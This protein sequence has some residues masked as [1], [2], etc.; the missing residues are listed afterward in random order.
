M[1]DDFVRCYIPDM[2]LATLRAVQ[3]E[4]G[5]LVGWRLVQGREFDL[6]RSYGYEH[7]IEEK[8]LLAAVAKRCIIAENRNPAGTKPSLIWNNALDI[9][10]VLTL[11]SIARGRFV[12]AS[13]VEKKIGTKYTL[14]RAL[15]VPEIAGRW[16][17]VPIERFGSFIREAMGH[18][19]RYPDWLKDSGFTP[20]IYTYT[21]AQIAYLTAPSI[22]EMGLYWVTIESIAG[23]YIESKAITENNKKERVKRFITDMGYAGSTWTFLEEVID[24]WYKT[25]NALFHEGKQELP[26]G[27]LGIRRQQ[28][29]DFTSLVLVEMLQKQGEAVRKEVATRIQDYK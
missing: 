7:G 26:I 6:E 8:D 19:E 17:I 24:D 11:L 15:I 1:S 28:A 13:F 18:I 16:D 4:S 14:S 27:L 22:L 23:T 3:E 29:R 2:S 12:S 21:Q 20:S 25:R 10:D 5:R 9:A